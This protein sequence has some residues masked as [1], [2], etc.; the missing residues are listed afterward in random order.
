MAYERIQIVG[1]IGSTDFLTSRNNNPFFRMSVGVNKD[2]CKTKWY[3]VIMTGAFLKDPTKL[4]KYKKGRL[5]LVEGRPDSEAY[6]KTDGSLQV[7]NT[8]FVITYPELLDAPT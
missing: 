7:D 6:A 2:G 3:T 5:V 8:I 1:K 4:N